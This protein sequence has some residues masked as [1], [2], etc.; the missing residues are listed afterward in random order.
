VK[1]AFTAWLV[2]S[3]GLTASAQSFYNLDFEQATLVP[4]PDDPY[5]R[6]YFD[7]AL[8]GWTGGLDVQTAANYNAEFLDSAGV[9]IFDANYTNEPVAAMKHGRYCVCLYSGRT[10]SGP[11]TFVETW[12]AQTGWIPAG[13]SNILFNF[14][15][16]Q[17]WG[18]AHVSV[19]FTGISIPLSV[20]SGG[21]T[22]P[23]VLRGDVSQFAGQVGELRF[24]APIDYLS[25]HTWRSIFLLDNIRF[26]STSP[27][28]GTP[29]LSQSAVVGTTVEFA[30]IA[31]GL[32]PLTYQW[33]FN[34]ANAL[35]GA[36]NSTLELVNV[37]LAQAGGYTVVVRN[38]FGTATSDPALLTVSGSPA[39]LTPPVNQATVAGTTVDF[40]VTAAGSP[41]LTYQWFFNGTNALDGAIHPTLELVNVQPA[42]AGAYTVVVTN[43]FG[44]VT[45]APAHLT[46]NGSPP[47]GTVVAWGENYYDYTIVPAGLGDVLA[48]AAGAF[49]SL[50]LKSDRTVVAWGDSGQTN[51]P[52]GLSNVLAIAAGDAYSLALRSD[53]TV[54]GWGNDSYGQ[55]N[56]PAG[57]KKVRAIAAGAQ[58]SLA[59]QT[60]GTVVSWGDNRGG[61]TNVPVGLSNV[62]AIAAGDAY[63]L[64]LRSDGTVVA[65][66]ANGLGQTNV[67][68][69]L[70]NAIAIAAGESHSLAVQSDGTVV[71][72]GN[73]SYGQTNVPAGL[74]NVIAV[75]AGWT[76][77]LALRSDGIV[78]TWGD[79]DLFDTT[80]PAGLSNVIAIAAGGF[81]N[82][83]L[84]AA[85]S[86]ARV[87][88]S[89][90]TAEIGASAAFTAAAKDD[91]SV[92]YQW[93]FNGTNAISGATTNACLHLANVQP[94]QA[95][96]YTVVVSDAF[97]AVTSAPATLSVI[98]VVERR[99]VPALTLIGQPGSSL[100]VQHAED[101]GPSPSW[102]ELDSRVLTNSSQWYFDLSAPLPPQRFYRALQ[103]STSSI[104]PALD[105]HMVPAITLNG[106]TGSSVR[107]DCIN[108]LGPV[109]AWVTLATVTL[110]NTYQLYFDTS[111]IGQPAR[112]YRLVS[113]P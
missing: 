75:A 14:S 34:Q 85:T 12:I 87:S 113:V 45:S 79:A 51:V 10:L 102:L 16:S 21:G 52:A 6:V 68:A 3:I 43:T 37:Q 81:H 59:L 17:S 80:M 36:T 60:G 88:P 107:V 86:L 58:H 101:L 105:L 33:F 62:L 49:H 27:V 104:V 72:W 48:I 89:S 5:G 41:P 46:V 76:Y 57:L 92:R 38:L 111:T 42:Q 99:L 91:P 100:N 94:W 1:N 64:A 110:T 70:R 40:A 7:G 112:L 4:V 13:V 93:F 50:A 44:A 29:P 98:P 54:V 8:P 31:D 15:P 67:P 25:G 47:V 30:V 78:V 23:S 97:G 22:G 69:G 66:G 2:A 109:D 96:A 19:T 56:V 9:S 103:T 106:G 28:I 65:W 18:D 82:L 39:I 35:S 61:Q 53:G 11:D 84:V 73:N 32:P 83:A 24:T 95:G 55:T 77:S 71:G 74:R 63:S 90:Q 20:L 26:S 108:Q